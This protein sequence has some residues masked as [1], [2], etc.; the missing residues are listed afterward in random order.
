MSEPFGATNAS[1]GVKQGSVLFPILFTL[2]LDD[3]NA[4]LEDDGDGCG[5]A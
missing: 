1:N 5:L 4:E 2:C 3:L